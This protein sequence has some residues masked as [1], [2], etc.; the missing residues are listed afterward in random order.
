MKKNVLVFLS[1]L[2][3]GMMLFGGTFVLASDGGKNILAKYSNIKI[4]VNGKLVQSQLEPFTYNDRVFVPL[5]AVAEAL[6]QQVGW[7]DNTVIITGGNSPKS[8]SIQDLFIPA[9][10]GLKYSVNSKMMVNEKEYKKGFYVSPTDKLAECKFTTVSSGLKQLTG[11]IAMDDES[12]GSESV[13]VTVFVNDK[14][15]EKM[16]L[17]KGEEPKP[18]SV[19][20]NGAG[21]IKFV[22]DEGTDKK[23]D[24]IN[25]AVRY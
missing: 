25:M 2:L 14:K 15:V 1:G 12:K 18:L 21:D 22:V 6:N 8:L 16:E 5:R 20:L 24:F 10:N 17:K 9:N 3:I 11:S 23:I 4:V 7:E 13:Y 19:N